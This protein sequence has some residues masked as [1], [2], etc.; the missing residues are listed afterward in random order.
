[1]SGGGTSKLNPVRACSQLQQVT[2]GVGPQLMAEAR[3][4]GCTS[5]G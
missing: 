5:Q 1:M 2:R 4:R 3:A